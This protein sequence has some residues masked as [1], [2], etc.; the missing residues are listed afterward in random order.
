MQR[1]GKL[2]AC[3]SELVQLTG[4]DLSGV[5]GIDWALL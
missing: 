5:D 1:A 2:G 3:H 4:E